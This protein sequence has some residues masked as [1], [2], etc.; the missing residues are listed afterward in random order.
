[1][2]TRRRFLERLVLLCVATNLTV[3]AGCA[4]QSVDP[5]PFQA[6]ELISRP[7]GCTQLLES[8]DRG[9]C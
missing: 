4:R 6:G 8:D 7:L 9:D 2:T 3:T 1:M 5:T